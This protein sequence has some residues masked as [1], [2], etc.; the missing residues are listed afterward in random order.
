ME[1]V[2]EIKDLLGCTSDNAVM[3]LRHFKWDVDKLQNNW[4]EQEDKLK[5][6]IGI[7]FDQNIPKRAAY[8]NASLKKNNQGMC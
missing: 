2:E 6:K 3:I 8:V 7:A 4:F 5:L 1:K